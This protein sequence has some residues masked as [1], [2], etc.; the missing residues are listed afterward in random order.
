MAHGE[1]WRIMARQRIAILV[2]SFFQHSQH[3]L[4]SKK[5][6]RCLFFIAYRWSTSKYCSCFFTIKRLHF[7]WKRL[8]FQLNRNKNIAA[9]HHSKRSKSR[10]LLKI[11][12]SMNFMMS[13]FCFWCIVWVFDC[14]WHIFCFYIEPFAAK[15][16]RNKY[17]TLYGCHFWTSK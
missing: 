3:L 2:V 8:H 13:P 10:M 1:I 6:F 12:D 11:T 7:I 4:K 16:Y 15:F 9:S 5:F 14:R 17:T